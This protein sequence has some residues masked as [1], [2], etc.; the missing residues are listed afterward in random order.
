MAFLKK[1]KRIIWII[2]KFVSLR[3]LIQVL[4]YNKILISKIFIEQLL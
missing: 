2:N 1:I 3:T 4:D